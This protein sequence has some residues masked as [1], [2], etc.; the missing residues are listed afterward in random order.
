[1][2]KIKLKMNCSGYLLV[3]DLLKGCISRNLENLIVVL[4][5]HLERHF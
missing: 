5:R 1:M 3:V 4:D 2:R